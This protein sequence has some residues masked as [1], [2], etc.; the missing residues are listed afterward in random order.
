MFVHGGVVTH[1]VFGYVANSRLADCMCFGAAK[2]GWGA[3]RVKH[4]V[5]LLWAMVKRRPT[6]S[7]TSAPEDAKMAS[8]LSHVKQFFYELHTKGVKKLLL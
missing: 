6:G 5:T 4:N 8:K 3:R 7:G 1:L 2:C